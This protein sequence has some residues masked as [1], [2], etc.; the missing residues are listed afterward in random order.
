MIKI[1]PAK[2]I[3]F[4]IAFTGLLSMV[5][6]LTVNPTEHIVVS[7]PGMDN[8]G[9]DSIDE[10]V[11][12]GS[13]FTRF[14][15][16]TP[17][18]SEV[19][20]AFRGANR[21]N[22]ATTAF[23]LKS[24]LDES[25]L[26]VVWKVHLGEGHAG[27]AIYKGQVFVLDYVEEQRTDMLRCFA[28][29]TGE[30]LW[31]RGYKVR[32]K[33]NH[34]MSRTVPAVTDDYVLTI[35]PRCHVMCVSRSTGDF[36]WGIDIEKEYLNETPLWYTGQCPLIDN[37][38]AIIATGGK[39]L[40]VGVDCATGTKLWETPNDDGWQMSHSSV[41]TYTFGGKKMY[42][43]AAIG[44]VAGISAEGSD[45]GKILWKTTLFNH[46]VV[47]PSALCLP[48]GT[49]FL[50]AGYGAGSTVLKL[51]EKS[52]TFTVRL[53]DKYL[54]REGLASEQ[55]TPVYW[56]GHV[57]GVMPKE[58]GIYRNQFV[59]VH[60]SNFRKMVWTSGKEKR[61]GLGPYFIADG[62]FFLL[63]DDAT[64]TIMRPSIK[65]FIELD[66]VKLFEGAD[67]W[68]PLATADGYLILRD[69]ET[70]ICLDM[71]QK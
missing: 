8:R 28:L 18:F 71:N 3:V 31:Q 16:N 10:E 35:G 7:Q 15:A 54:P 59:C 4:L 67:A 39:S 29:N 42:I 12:I 9:S 60:P 24:S 45:E 27:A 38:K 25:A 14:S 40:L 13:L 26:P 5:F 17:A 23:R 48:D 43:Y 32:I 62:K 49:I 63:N 57:F 36:L 30:E 44:G 11:N 34:G 41:M 33:R 19:W 51:S 56:N 2:I 22:I 37:G 65:E 64:L 21:D 66:E 50:T 53:V 55:Q 69:S 46:S 52:G 20:P 6:W 70:M 68:A 1:S 61:Y 47:A 58:G